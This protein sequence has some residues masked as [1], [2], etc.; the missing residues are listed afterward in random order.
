MF[1]QECSQ[2]SLI[3]VFMYI[4]LPLLD[5]LYRLSLTFIEAWQLIADLAKLAFDPKF[6]LHGGAPTFHQTI[7][8]LP[9]LNYSLTIIAN[10]TRG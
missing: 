2:K 6:Q 7:Y 10:T 9:A 8:W 5:S 3:R 1:C 4:V